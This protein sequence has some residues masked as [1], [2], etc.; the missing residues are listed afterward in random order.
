MMDK[1]TIFTVVALV[2][3]IIIITVSAPINAGAMQTE[4]CAVL[5]KHSPNRSPQVINGE[6]YLLVGV[7]EP[8]T[9]MTVSDYGRMIL[10]DGK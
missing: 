3:I 6:C 4:M 5:S 9:M 10:E 8:R 7:D 1:H 2:V